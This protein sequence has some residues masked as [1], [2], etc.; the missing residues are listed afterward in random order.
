MNFGEVFLSHD[1]HPVAMTLLWLAGGLGIASL[2][3][4]G[5]AVSEHLP[6]ASQKFSVSWVAVG[7]FFVSSVVIILI[8]VLLLIEALRY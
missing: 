3:A 6:R 8:E 2:I 7:T 4:L 1:D 5:L